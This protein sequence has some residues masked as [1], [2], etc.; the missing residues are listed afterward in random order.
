MA[1][2][3][4]VVWVLVANSV[5]F[6]ST[7][8]GNTWEPRGLPTPI[9]GRN[10]I[11][12]INDHEGW[13]LA[14]GSPETQCNGASAVIW[15]TRDAGATWQQ[16]SSV[17][18]AQASGNG[19]A[20]AQ[21]KEYIYFYDPT[22]GF[23]TAW[24]D[25]HRPTIYRTSDGGKTWSGSTLPDPPDFKTSPGGFTLRA[26]IFKRF[27]NTLYVEAWGTQ[28]G[29]IPN[30]QYMFRSTDNGA[31]WSW[32]MKIPSRYIAMVSESR[33][34]QLIWPGQSMESIN[35]GQQWHPYASDFSS[36]TPVGGP[37]IVFADSQVG[38]AEG[39]GALQRTVDGG[40]HWVRIATPGTEF[41]VPTSSPA[42]SA[43]RTKFNCDPEAAK[44]GN[45][46]APAVAYDPATK[47]V[48]YFGGTFNAES[49]YCDTW[50]WT[51]S[52]WSHLHPAHHPS[53]R[54][55]AYMAFDYQANR[56]LLY[57]G[58]NYL[59]DPRVF[60]AWFWDGSDWNLVLGDGGPKLGAV[61][62]IASAPNLG[63][64]LLYPSGE[65]NSDR[66]ELI[67]TYRWTAAGW[68]TIPGLGPAGKIAPGFTYDGDIGKFVKFGGGMGPV[69]PGD[70]G[71]W[72]FD[73]VTWTQ[74][75]P[76]GPRPSGNGSM[77]YD[78]THKQVVWFGDDGTWT[79]DGAAWT[80]RAS[81][82][83]SPPYGMWGA[84]VFDPVH[85]QVLAAGMMQGD[86]YGHTFVWDGEKWTAY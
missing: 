39:R 3:T 15:H 67:A 85:G 25:N 65:V 14:P 2:S 52:A 6:R 81:A 62:T 61:G 73:G 45:R 51:G 29:D 83:D 59:N 11:T 1:P 5:L 40:L 41:P 24:D 72:T 46:A 78:A 53:G 22:H 34:L 28:E 64:F 17:Q 10:A 35:S 19:I 68:K 31:T 43:A 26:T 63:V 57:G 27:G 7:N 13:V 16:V 12:F 70:T 55:F 49:G 33:W 60:D 74:L 4:N 38:Y 58:G 76:L 20:F 36:D 32:L 30:R 79:F 8:Q 23:V 48:L 84:M 75:N 86:G 44:P 47:Q 80:Q 66:Q 56:M 71:T 42:A 21:C 69:G 54:S 9:V 50:V 37:Q 77:T 82:A 18:S